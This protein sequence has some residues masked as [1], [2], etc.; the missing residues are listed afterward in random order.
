MCPFCHSDRFTEFW[1]ITTTTKMTADN[2]TQNICVSLFSCTALVSEIH[3][4][5]KLVGIVRFRFEVRAKLKTIFI[6]LLNNRKTHSNFKRK[7]DR[8]KKGST[9]RKRSIQLYTIKI[10]KKERKSATEKTMKNKHVQLC[11]LNRCGFSAH[12]SRYTYLGCYFVR[13]SK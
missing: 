9:L 10:K 12:L 6:L 11:V 2:S 3:V 1:T 8:E 4:F 7:W 5:Y 13:R